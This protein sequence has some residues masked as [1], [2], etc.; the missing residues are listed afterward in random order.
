MKIM[1]FYGWVKKGNAAETAT[2]GNSNI[3]ILK[4]NYKGKNVL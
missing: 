2:L 4:L 3:V 1:I